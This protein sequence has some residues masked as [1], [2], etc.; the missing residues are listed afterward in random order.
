MFTVEDPV[1]GYYYPAVK[2]FVNCKF[3]W[4]SYCA[5]KRNRIF[6]IVSSFPS[7]SSLFIVYHFWAPNLYG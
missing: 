4:A 3:N 1:C 5:T 6:E 7:C 2:Q